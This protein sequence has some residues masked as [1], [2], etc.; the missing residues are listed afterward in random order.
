MASRLDRQIYL[1]LNAFLTEN[2]D[3]LSITRTNNINIHTFL[4]EACIIFCLIFKKWVVLTF[5]LKIQNMKFY[6]N[7]SVG[8]RVFDMDRRKGGER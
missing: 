1:D 8:S 3:S 7:P 6:K 2:T 4:Y 5:L